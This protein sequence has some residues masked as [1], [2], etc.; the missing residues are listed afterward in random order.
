M[1]YIITCLLAILIYSLAVEQTITGQ[2]GNVTGA[3][4]SDYSEMQ[5]KDFNERN[6]T[7]SIN[8][9]GK[10]FFSLVKLDKPELI[11]IKQQVDKG[12]YAQAF[13]LFRARFV[14][15]LREI[16]FPA[17]ADIYGAF[18]AYSLAPAKSNPDELMQGIKTM[19]IDGKDV[20]VNIGKPGYTNWSYR[21]N[22]NNAPAQF[23]NCD[24]INLPTYSSLLKKAADTKNPEYMKRWFEYMDD[25]SL[26]IYRVPQKDALDCG[27]NGAKMFGGTEF[28]RM[29]Y[30]LTKVANILPEDGEGLPE[31]SLAR[32]LKM[33]I[34]YYM[35]DNVVR[36]RVHPQN[37]S[38][39]TPIAATINST[40]LKDFY[41]GDFIFT[42]GWQRS[43][44][45][46]SQQMYSDGVERQKTFAYDAMYLKEMGEAVEM[47]EIYRP[48][49]LTANRKLYLEDSKF[50]RANYIVRMLQSKGNR[51]FFAY[52]DFDRVF[53]TADHNTY[54]N[55]LMQYC[56]RAY[57]DPV[58]SAIL[59][60]TMGD[61]RKTP[62]RLPEINSDGFPY[63]GYYFI[64][65][66]WDPAD[67]YG[68]LSAT[69][70]GEVNK[71][72]AEN[73]FVLSAFDQYMITNDPKGAYSSS[74]SPLTVDGMQPLPDIG[75][76]VPGH[77]KLSVIVDKPNPFRNHNSENF[78]F[79]E[80]IYSGYYTP[81]SSSKR[82]PTIQTQVIR[83]GIHDVVHNRQVSFLR[84]CRL[85]IVTDKIASPNIHHYTLDWRLYTKEQA[86]DPGQKNFT[87]E[88]V[89]VDSVRRIIRTGDENIANIS[90]YCYGSTPF[91]MKKSFEKVP[92][93]SMGG[94]AFNNTK[95]TNSFT[96]KGD[97]AFVTVIY[98]RETL[99]EE[100]RSIEEVS[101]NK[102]V[103]AKV[104]FNDGTEV[105][106]Q[107][108]NGKK[109]DLNVAGIS[110]KGETLILQKD[111]S[112]K[113]RGMAFGCES[114]SIN[115][116]KQETGGAANFEF[117]IIKG[118]LANIRPF[119]T[120]LEKVEIFPDANTFSNET[121]ITMKY[122]PGNAVKIIYTLDGSDPEP[123]SKSAIL[124]TKPFTINRTT[125]VKAKAF[126]KEVTKTPQTMNATLAS[127]VTVAEY[128]KIE[129]KPA[130]R[131][132]RNQLENGL[133]FR[134]YDTEPAKW[135]LLFNHTENVGVE[136]VA[137]KEGKSGLMDISIADYS[138]P[139]GFDYYGYIDIPANGDY[140]FHVPEEFYK[141]DI[142]S[143]YNLLLYVDGEKWLPVQR[144][145]ALGT[146]TVALEKGLHKFEVR[147]TDFRKD[148]AIVKMHGED[149]MVTLKF[150]RR[151]PVKNFN[152]LLQDYVWS[153][154]RPDIYISGPAMEKQIVPGKMLF[155][156]K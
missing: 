128:N 32:F 98:P 26:N 114:F 55:K 117:G 101:G 105:S 138:K 68:I 80:G 71:T 87:Y 37:W 74:S 146:W 75:K 8:K 143:G 122:E 36:V 23:P 44:T 64:R 82:S 154:S 4:Q 12:N 29:M 145:H 140:T 90:L 56:K 25:L 130:Q 15:N 43:D 124:Y 19:T 123:E 109:G 137:Q 152:D 66:G 31:V 103:G 147:Y 47:M 106:Y 112:G 121:K 63:G 20:K 30:E 57:E 9:L 27:Y 95:I 48:D 150:D 76:L 92:A 67:Q 100:V 24:M 86:G 136:P 50:L 99:A 60:V 22:F 141:H 16:N 151:N 2:I 72:R 88:K 46:T 6:S 115:H 139:F 10:E 81:E 34:N 13:K 77:Q 14:K 133:K 127:L 73:V 108:A 35:P 3:G 134:Y 42:E 69:N 102:S 94:K 78:D 28:T 155:V 126:R 131:I 70:N 49:Y 40:F 18:V 51:P 153:G 125:V 119:Y 17:H 116:K 59:S 54:N 5:L 144:K 83:E 111:A 93:E 120:P 1:R 113:T 45:Y 132:A 110:L 149:Q 85:W 41:Y 135:G 7:E 38:I 129:M 97:L 118:R 39:A 58:T 91:S 96:D 61:Q 89:H 21:I 104:V 107:T 156:E 65:E 148:K 142:N 52:P 11:P 53:A 33:V 79:A 84:D 62:Y